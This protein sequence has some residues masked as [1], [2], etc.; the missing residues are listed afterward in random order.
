[1]TKGEKTELQNNAFTQL[2][3]NTKRGRGMAKPPTIKD[4]GKNTTLPEGSEAVP[5]VKSN[6]RTYRVS[7]LVSNEAGRRLEG[8]ITKIREKEG[9][10]PKIADVIERGLLELE[11]DL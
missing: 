3:K 2:R 6:A 8:L 7:T 1:M 9:K 5:V 11:R 10:K 4:A